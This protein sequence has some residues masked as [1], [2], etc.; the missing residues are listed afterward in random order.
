MCVNTCLSSLFFKGLSITD[1][2]QFPEE[3]HV[4]GNE[5]L[6]EYFEMGHQVHPAVYSMYIVY[7]TNTFLNFYD[8]KFPRISLL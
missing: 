5:K 3:G 6:L 8:T 2:K 4:T 7:G 1:R